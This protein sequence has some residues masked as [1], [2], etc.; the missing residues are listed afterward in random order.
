[1][2][3]HSRV[4][5]A[6]YRREI[7][8]TWHPSRRDLKLPN[9]HIYAVDL[10]WPRCTD[11]VTSVGSL[12]VTCDST[13]EHQGRSARW[14]VISRADRHIQIV[15]LTFGLAITSCSANVRKS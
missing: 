2:S 4:E 15:E 7:D 11:R 10:P 14:A 3:K 13:R 8:F 5:D 9:Y 6:S 1:M 12:G